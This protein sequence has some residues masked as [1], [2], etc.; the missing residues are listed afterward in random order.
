MFIYPRFLHFLYRRALHPC[1]GCDAGECLS[2]F[3]GVSA[4]WYSNTFNRIVHFMVLHKQFLQCKQHP[5]SVYQCKI[6]RR[7]NLPEDSRTV[8]GFPSLWGRI[9][10]RLGTKHDINGTSVGVPRRVRY[11][12]V[13]HQGMK[14]IKLRFLLCIMQ[15]RMTNATHTKIKSIQLV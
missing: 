8:V 7:F 12:V 2:S 9:D 5:W 14:T 10:L 3:L 1:C 13:V 6:G 4:H 15:M 11:S